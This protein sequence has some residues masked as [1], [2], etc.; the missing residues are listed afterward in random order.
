VDVCPFRHLPERQ[1]TYLLI[2]KVKL[3][4]EQATSQFRGKVGSRAGGFSSICLE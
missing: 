3:A 1:Q 2:L 4:A